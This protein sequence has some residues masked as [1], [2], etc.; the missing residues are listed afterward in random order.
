[1]ANQGF[2]H[3]SPAAMQQSNHYAML[4]TCYVF[5]VILML[6]KTLAVWDVLIL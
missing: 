2:E 5:L 1:M 4:A 3:G 6:L